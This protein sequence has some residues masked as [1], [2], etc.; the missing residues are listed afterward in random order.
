MPKLGRPSPALIVAIAAVVLAS[1]GTAFA[2]SKI[3]GSDIQNRTITGPKVKLATLGG[4][5]L[6]ARSV[7][8]GKLRPFTGGL[9]KDKTIPGK[10]LRDKSITGDQI[11]TS[12][13]GPVP[14]AESLVGDARYSAKLEFGKTEEVAEVAPFKLV[15]QC[16]SD[17]TDSEGQPNR[18]VARVL[19]ATAEAG[20]VFTSAIGSKDGSSADELLNPTTAE[21]QRVVLEHSV[22]TGQS[23]FGLAGYLN[24][25]APNGTAISVAQGAASAA[26]NVG[27]T[28]CTFTGAVTSVR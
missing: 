7:G 1:A 11:D 28:G 14:E 18:D 12:K 8:G 19:I 22:P 9:I 10:K 25:L 16:L 23:G 20:S 26:I 15:A 5:H 17:V 21:G 4:V 2:T 6:R 27:G 24:A 3:N 13:L